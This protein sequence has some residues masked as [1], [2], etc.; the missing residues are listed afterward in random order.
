VI[1]AI[2]R[3]MEHDVAGDPITGVR[4]TRRTT[5]KISEELQ[6]LD[7]HVCPRTVAR[8]LEDLDYALRVN[9]K[10]VSQGSG[11][12]RNEQFEYIAEQRTRF[13]ERDLPIVSIDSKKKELIGNF[14]NP[15]TTWRRTPELVYD[16]DFR[17]EADGFAIPYGVY[18]VRANRGTV[19]VGTSHDTSDFAVDNL[20]RWW[21]SEGVERYRDASE[22]LV[23]ADG[24]GSNNP[25]HRAF[26][27]ALQTRLADPYRLSVTLCHYPTGASKWNPVEHRL[28]SAISNNWAGQP[29]RSYEVM[30][31][32]IRTTTTKTGL[33]VSAHLID[34]DYPTAVKVSDDQIASLTLERH[35][36]QPLRNYT[37]H[38]RS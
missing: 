30:L 20:S 32:Y 1:A 11:P 28:F 26:K 19:Y 25:R 16:H 31:K 24:G 7:I 12:D 5:K 15:G 21:A 4:W 35:E 22:L 17:S 2:E 23:L 33:R 6:A 8:L 34:Q 36:I 29:L 13:R 27:Y 14:K 38:P 37:I 18:D 3:L 10:R 9:H